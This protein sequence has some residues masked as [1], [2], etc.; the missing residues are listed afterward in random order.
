[1]HKIKPCKIRN[2]MRQKLKSV[3]LKHITVGRLCRNSWSRLRVSR[4]AD[5][6][7]AFCDQNKN[8]YFITLKEN[9]S[10]PNLL[11]RPTRPENLFLQ[12][13]GKSLSVS[14]VLENHILQLGDQFHRILKINLRSRDPRMDLLKLS[15]N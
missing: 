14:S 12:N 1:M 11:F 13:F 2:S 7:R 4:A 10:I 3:N 5:C 6:D 15:L 9:T 8:L